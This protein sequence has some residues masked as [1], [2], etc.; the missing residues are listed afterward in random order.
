MQWQPERITGLRGALARAIGLIRL[1]G[2]NI[3]ITTLRQYL[4]DVFETT[5]VVTYKPAGDKNTAGFRVTDF[6]RNNVMIVVAGLES[7]AI[8]ANCLTDFVNERGDMFG[9][10]QPWETG[11]DIFTNGVVAGVGGTVNQVVL[12]GHSWGAAIAANCGPKLTSQPSN[13]DYIYT[14]GGPPALTSRR[15]TALRQYTYRR[16]FTRNDPVVRLTGVGTIV[17]GVITNMPNRSVVS[18]A[19]YVHQEPGLQ[20][21][22]TA[23]PTP[24]MSTAVIPDFRLVGDLANWISG[25]DMLGSPDHSLDA[26]SRAVGSAL[27]SEQA[28][29]DDRPPLAVRQRARPMS[30]ADIDTIRD[31]AIGVSSIVTANNTG[32]AAR[33]A[34]AAVT[35]MP[36]V[37]WHGKKVR[38]RRWLY[39]G[40]QM[41]MPLHSR[42]NQISLVRYLNK[43]NV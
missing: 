13:S 14:F 6:T 20:V 8:V 4:P 1:V 27:T 41:V 43:N 15:E 31:S 9:F 5:D 2:P 21:S 16:C 28:A 32:A 7:P 29:T 34:Q 38:G 19:R 23:D 10:P 39:Y 3:D 24:L 26:Y 17:G 40:E 36:G 30:P 18:W 33:E 37:K 12:I 42:R 11:A 22:E 35:F 25:T